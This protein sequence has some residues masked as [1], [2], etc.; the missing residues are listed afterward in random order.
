MRLQQQPGRRSRRERERDQGIERVVPAAREPLGVGCRM[1]GDEAGV[2]PDRFD[3]GRA[4]HHPVSG[5][6]LGGVLDAV[7]GQSDAEAHG[8]GRYSVRAR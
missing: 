5:D 1:V 2:E 4:F 3:R 8:G 6:E 7:G